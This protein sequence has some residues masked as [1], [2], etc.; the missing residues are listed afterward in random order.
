MSQRPLSRRATILEL[1]LQLAL[2]RGDLLRGGIAVDHDPDL[3]RH[4]PAR[5]HAFVHERVAAG[6]DVPG[7][8]WIVIDRYPPAEEI[9]AIESELE[10]EFE[11]RRATAERALTHR[12]SGAEQA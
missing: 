4:V 8:V 2:D 3:A 6:R 11:D 12:N 9:A 7:E 5:R 10:S 1:A